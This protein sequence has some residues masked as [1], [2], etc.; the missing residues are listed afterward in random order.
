[1]GRDERINPVAQQVVGPLEIKDFRGRVLQEGDEIL[2][3][4]KT[5]VSYRVAEIVPFVNPNVPGGQLQVRL[6]TL[7]NFVAARG[8]IN[9]EFARIQTAEEAGPMPISIS[10]ENPELREE[11]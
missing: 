3:F 11:S 1:M 4:T 6:V 10:H 7:V 5:P 2:L 8:S 9:M